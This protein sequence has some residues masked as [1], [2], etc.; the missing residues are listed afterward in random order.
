MVET[1]PSLHDLLDNPTIRRLRSMLG[2]RDDV[3]VT[4]SDTAGLFLWG[5]AA[6]SRG[7]FDRS[8]EDYV[9]VDRFSYLHPEDVDRCRRRFASAVAG[10][11]VS[12]TARARAEDGSWRTVAVLEW[13]TDGPAGPVVLTVTLPSDEPPEDLAFLDSLRA[14]LDRGEG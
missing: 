14:G 1:P 13:P 7:M 2:D 9:G 11:T 10:D 6:G 8:P 3:V 4:V 12:Y 5:T